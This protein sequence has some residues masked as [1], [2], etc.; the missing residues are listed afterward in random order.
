[1]K[2]I[3]FLISIALLIAGNITTKSYAQENIRAMIKQCENMEVFET[4][5]VSKYPPFIKKFNRSTTLIKLTST[6]AL[7]RQWE[8]AFR[9][10]GDKAIHA[11]EQKKDGKVNMLYRFETSTYTYTKSNDVINIIESIE[12]KRRVGVYSFFV[13]VVPDNYQFPLIGFINTAIGSHQGLQAGF[14]NTTLVDFYGAQLGFVNSTFDNNAGL[15]AGFVNTTFNEIKGLQSGFVNLAGYGIQNVGQIGFVNMMRKGINGAQIGYVNATGGSVQG[16]QIGFVNFTGR[17][18]QGGQFGFVNISGGKVKDAQIGF[19]NY[20]D[21]ISGVPIGFLSIVKKGGYRAI[22]VSVNEFY[23]V[24]LS[25]KIGVP[26]LYTF[27]QGSYN[28]DFEHQFASGAGLGSLIPLGKRFY[29]NPEISTLNTISRDNNLQIQS[30][31]GNIRCQITPQLSIAA[32]TSVIHSYYYDGR[33][34]SYKPVYSI[35]NHEINNKNR[36]FV[37]ARAALTV[38]F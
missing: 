29:F 31:V 33:N 16:A 8:E 21:S 34:S 9:Q 14:V 4:D 24:N 18:V 7:E 26:I 25:F 20:A 6:P 32:G 11:A 5:V 36:L 27:F 30:F 35:V 15:Q 22:E 10:D 23:P 12:T 1:M 38:N 28:P 37:G 13:N 2:K 19:V 17:S 3:N